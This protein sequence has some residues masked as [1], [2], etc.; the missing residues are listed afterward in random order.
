M[1]RSIEKDNKIQKLCLRK[2]QKVT[3]QQVYCQYSYIEFQLVRING[4]SISLF[5]NS[6]TGKYL[7]SSNQICQD[8]V[9]DK[10]HSSEYCTGFSTA[11]TN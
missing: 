1:P 9:F 7:F 8:Y 5:W 3:S 2:V 6:L 11:I 10:C 4:L